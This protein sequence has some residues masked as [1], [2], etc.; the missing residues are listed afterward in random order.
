MARQIQSGRSAE[1]E[2]RR[3][4]HPILKRGVAGLV[5]VVAAVLVIH[6]VVHLVMA[7][8]WVVAVIAVIVAV[9]WA[10]KELL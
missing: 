1:V 9:V 10:A 3:S 6:V 2:Q 4:T 7:V 5:L 8:F